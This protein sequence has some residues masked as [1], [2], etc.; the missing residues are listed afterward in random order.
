MS[1]RLQSEPGCQ[2]LMIRILVAYVKEVGERTEAD[3]VCMT[4]I[5]G[6]DTCVHISEFFAI[7]IDIAVVHTN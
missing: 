7:L 5:S 4:P 3:P 6:S 1:N 2:Q